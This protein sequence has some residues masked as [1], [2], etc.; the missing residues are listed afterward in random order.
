MN[1]TRSIA[2]GHACTA[3]ATRLNNYYNKVREGAAA[4]FECKILNK[5]KIALDNLHWR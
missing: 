4:C 2:R 1:C 3:A 5:F